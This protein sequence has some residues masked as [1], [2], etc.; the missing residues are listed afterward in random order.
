MINSIK[1]KNFKSLSIPNEIPIKPILLLVGPNSSGKSSILQVFLLFKQTIDS[2]DM[3]NPL[4]LNGKYVSLGSFNDIIF[5]HDEKLNFEVEFT[6]KIEKNRRFFFRLTPP[7]LKITYERGRITGYRR[8]D[9]EKYYREFIDRYKFNP[10]EIDL[11]KVK[12]S[13]AYNEDKKRIEVDSYE[14]NAINKGNNNITLIKIEKKGK[15]I[16]I[17][18]LGL[19]DKQKKEIIK[20][21]SRQKFYYIFSE[22]HIFEYKLFRSPLKI[23]FFNFLR[24]VTSMVPSIFQEEFEKIF[25][26]GPL[27]EYPKRYYIATGETPVDVGLRGESAVD[28]IFK[29]KFSEKTNV[30]GKLSKWF[31]KFNLANKVELKQIASNLSQVRVEDPHT[32]IPVNISDIGFGASQILPLVVEGFHCPEKS[33]VISEQPE[34]H[35]HP[36]VQADLGDLL[37]DIAKENKFLLVETHSEHLLARIRRRIAEKRIKKEIVKIYYFEPKSNGT[38]IEEIILDEKGQYIHFP[39]GFFEEDFEEAI[40]H[41]KALK[42]DAIKKNE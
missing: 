32:K 2:R 33:I 7:P 8:R 19:S 9:M 37:I 34:I 27:R 24:R 12:T 18:L 10:S 36:K 4:L 14:I 28:V 30:A 3:E 41:L 23:G 31:T 21:R 40:K 1:I 29:D 17:P 15:K 35:L 22:R 5:G 6:F 16:S 20:I 42:K 13:F 26:L 38:S 25:Y 11:L 39:K